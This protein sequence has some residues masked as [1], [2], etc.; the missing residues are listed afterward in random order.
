MRGWFQRKRVLSKKLRGFSLGESLLAMFVLSVGLL[1]VVALFQSALRNSF[2]VRDSIIASQ[3]AQE[4]IELARNARDN[5]F[6]A[7]GDGFTGA[8]PTGIST[9]NKHCWVSY[10]D[11]R[12]TC[13]GSQG[14]L[15]NENLVYTSANPFYRSTNSSATRFVR[16]LYIDYDSTQKKADI[17]SFVLWDGSPLPPS[18]GS[19]ANCTI[20]HKCVYAEVILTSW[21][22][23]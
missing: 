7:G 10:E 11:S 20:A 21:L 22:K 18:N 19:T 1:T 9:P 17:K 8:P 4:G 5:N 6:A 13:Y 3:L 23:P 14:N 12:V 2:E 15:V 16:Y